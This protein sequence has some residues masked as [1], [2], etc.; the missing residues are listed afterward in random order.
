MPKNYFIFTAHGNVAVPEVQVNTGYRIGLAVRRDS[1][2]MTTSGLTHNKNVAALFLE[3]IVDPSEQSLILL[4]TAFENYLRH[5][6]DQSAEELCALM[7]W[8]PKNT[9][10]QHEYGEVP[11]IENTG[12]LIPWTF[13]HGRLGPE[14]EGRKGFRSCNLTLRIAENQFTFKALFLERLLE[15][16]L[17]LYL[18][19]QSE[20]KSQELLHSASDIPFDSC[21]FITPIG[22]G[23][24][25]TTTSVLELIKNIRI[26]GY[27][28]RSEI[29]SP[30]KVKVQ[31]QL[32]DP[33]PRKNIKSTTKVP[34][35]F[36]FPESWDLNEGTCIFFNSCSTEHVGLI[37]SAINR[38][39]S[40]VR[41]LSNLFTD[42]SEQQQENEINTKAFI[43]AAYLEQIT[44]LFSECLSEEEKLRTLKDFYS[45]HSELDS[46]GQM[47]DRDND[48]QSDFTT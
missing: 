44:S 38:V 16:Q 46:I 21:I 27:F 28:E 14:S 4:K 6:G 22:E 11:N 18:E 13:G 1:G 8:R 43:G 33:A 24:T 45:I 34:F 41:K 20:V 30:C 36:A 19:N 3:C 39:V 9:N 12:G 37:S 40:S 42:F 35:C 32:I 15:L 2:A 10:R 23:V 48:A 26:S 17:M 47:G 7:E 25:V 5:L 29:G 31:I